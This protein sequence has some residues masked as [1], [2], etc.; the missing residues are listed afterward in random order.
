MRVQVALAHVLC[1]PFPTDLLVG[2]RLLSETRT[3]LAALALD[4]SP[5]DLRWVN[6]QDDSGTDVQ[7]P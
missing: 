6:L 7:S 3:S 1:Q 4:L 5:D 2:W